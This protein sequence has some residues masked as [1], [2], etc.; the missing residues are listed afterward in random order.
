MIDNVRLVLCDIDGTLVTTGRELTPK[1]KEVIDRLHAN[2]IYFG[3]ASG[4]SIDQQLMTFSKDWG[5]D[6]QFEI[7]IG[8]NGSELWDDLSQKRYDFYKLSREAIKEIVELMEPFDLNPFLYHDGKMLC[9]RLDQLTRQSSKKNHAG[10]IVAK[11]ISELYAHENAK[12][13][14]RIPEEQMPEIEAYVNAHPSPNFRGFK[15]QTTMLEFTD[16]RVSKDVALKK[17][18][19]ENDISLE[20]VISFGDISNDNEMLECSGW[21]VCLLNGADDTKAIADDITEK[22]NDEDGFAHYI[23]KHFLEPRGW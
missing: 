10:V 20:Q 13:M 11:D 21:G 16:R 23:E 1:T 17:F 8:M 9:K 6:Y 3:L 2:G 19:E 18:C 4:R 12:I 5:F 15:T 14:Y 7:L 22:T